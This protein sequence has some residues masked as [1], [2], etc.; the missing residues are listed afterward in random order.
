[1]FA[2]RSYLQGLAHFDPSMVVRAWINFS[3]TVPTLL[4][5]NNVS[6]LSRSSTGKYVI[7]WNSGTVASAYAQVISTCVEDTTNLAR[8][9]GSLNKDVAEPATATS[10]AIIVNQ[11]ATDAVGDSSIITVAV[12]GPQ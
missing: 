5:S 4:G 6:S 1:M 2:T 12:I 8:S 10:V 3:G 9:C 11:Q 7:T